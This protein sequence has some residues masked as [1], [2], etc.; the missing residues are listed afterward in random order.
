MF[1]FN[2]QIVPL[3]KIN[4]HQDI[5]II[6]KPFTPPN[7]KSPSR[8]KTPDNSSDFYNRSNSPNFRGNTNISDQHLNLLADDIQSTLNIAT[9]E[10]SLTDAQFL[11]FINYFDVGVIETANSLNKI[12][13]ASSWYVSLNIKA[14]TSKL[15]QDPNFL[16]IEFLLD[17]GA[18]ICIIN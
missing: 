7:S 6:L 13:A 8:S 4:F 14:K 2:H 16:E 15:K 5:I 18:T 11:E 3:T 9:N 1:H 12:D 10:N 17:T